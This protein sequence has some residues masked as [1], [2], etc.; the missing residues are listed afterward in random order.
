MAKEEQDH[1]GVWRIRD[2]GVIRHQPENHALR[3]LGKR[4][5]VVNEMSPVVMIAI[6]NSTRRKPFLQ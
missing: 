6:A 1:D 2:S 5:I 4:K 3:K